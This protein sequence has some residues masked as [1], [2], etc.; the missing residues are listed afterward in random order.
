MLSLLSLTAQGRGKSWVWRVKGA[1][2]NQQPQQGEH[3]C[4]QV[5]RGGPLYKEKHLISIWGSQQRTFGGS[6]RTTWVRYKKKSQ[7]LSFSHCLYQHP[8]VQHLLHVTN[9]EEATLLLRLCLCQHNCSLAREESAYSQCDTAQ[10]GRKLGDFCWKERWG[11][12]LK[13]GHLTR[14]TTL[15]SNCMSWLKNW[16]SNQVILLG[17]HALAS[18]TC[19]AKRFICLYHCHTEAYGILNT[20][21]TGSPTGY[22]FQIWKLRHW[23]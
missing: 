19:H 12:L 6:Q 3:Q 1:G 22:I 14:K 17:V 15:I 5:G 23:G 20:W 11:A 13:D 10:S 18:S 21:S 9:R 2:W 7:K 4:W 8:A 16:Q